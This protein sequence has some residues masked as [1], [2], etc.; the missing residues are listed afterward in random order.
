VISNLRAPVAI[1]SGAIAVLAG[2]AAAFGVFARGD[3]TYVSVVSARGETY[4]MA[5]TG[6]YAYNALRVVAEGVGWDVFTLLVAAPTLLAA[7]VLLARGSFSATLVTGG[8]LGYFVYMYLEYTVTWAFGPLFPLFVVI[9]AASLVALIGVGALVQQMGVQ[10][11]F[12]DAFPRRTW[13]VVAVG[14][15]VMLTAMWSAR[16]AGALTAAVPALEG[17]TTMTVQA[18]DLGVMVPVTFV[19]VALALRRL[20]VGLAASAAF[21][22]TYVAMSAAI[23]SMLISAWIASGVIEAVPI[24]IFGLAAIAGLVTAIRMHRSIR[25]AAGRAMSPMRGARPADLPAAG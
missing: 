17:E 8:M 11:R 1:L 24:S 22:V 23:G 19:L 13:A 12:G 18:L 25:P 15:A 20:P 14:M 6:V 21:A 7:S 2:V 4:E 10:D 5:T 16:I 9:L 3:G